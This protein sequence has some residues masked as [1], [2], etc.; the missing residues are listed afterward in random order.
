MTEIT[1]RC[2][3]RPRVYKGVLSVNIFYGDKYLGSIRTGGR[4]DRESVA[5]EGF[6]II[7]RHGLFKVLKKE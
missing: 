1:G 2:F 3:F 5:A 4:I 7:E 6:K